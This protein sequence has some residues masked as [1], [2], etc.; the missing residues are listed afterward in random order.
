MGNYGLFKTPIWNRFTRNL[1]VKTGDQ[2]WV[3]TPSASSRLT[4]HV[5][6]KIAA[7]VTRQASM[8][9]RVWMSLRD[10]MP[11]TS[12]V[13]FLLTLRGEDGWMCRERRCYWENLLQFE[14]NI[15]R[16]CNFCWHV[17]IIRSRASSSFFLWGSSNS[18]QSSSRIFNQ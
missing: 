1:A 2:W 6:F 11:M 4:S 7:S 18:N 14:K 10:V 15:S 9:L 16:S 17:D 3:V 12:A 13:N 5:L 8:P